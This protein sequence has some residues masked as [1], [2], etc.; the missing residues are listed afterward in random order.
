MLNFSFSAF[1]AFCEV[2][3]FDVTF[4][5]KSVGRAAEPKVR[6]LTRVIP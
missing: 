4:L 2:I 3:I 6:T 1:Q 5:V